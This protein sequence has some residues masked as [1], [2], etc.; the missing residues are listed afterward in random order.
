MRTRP[1]DAI[2]CRQVAC[3]AVLSTFLIRQVL[4]ASPSASAPVWWFWL[5]P[6][7]GI[8]FDTGRHASAPSKALLLVRLLA[9]WLDLPPTAAARGSAAAQRAAR[10]FRKLAPGAAAGAG[11]L[12]SLCT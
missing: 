3:G 1:H 11:A 5:A 9:E 4:D 7:S 10:A 12:M 2:W 6:G 8:F